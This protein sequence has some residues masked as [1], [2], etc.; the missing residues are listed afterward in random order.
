MCN[1]G[2]E[3]R[4]W[5]LHI[6]TKGTNKADNYACHNINDYCELLFQKAFEKKVCAI[7]ITDYFSIE[8]YLEVK[9]YQDAID[10]KPTLT[11]EEKTF[12]K[13]ILLLPNVELRILPV[14][15]KDRLINIHCIFK[16]FRVYDNKS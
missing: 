1:R 16:T 13:G 7:G 12:V 4:R 2:S 3:W 10:S 5:D 11:E 6:H 8:R 15:G 14:T 9:A